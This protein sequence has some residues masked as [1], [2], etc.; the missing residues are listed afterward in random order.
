MGDLRGRNQAVAGGQKSGRWGE[1]QGAWGVDRRWGQCH[2][3]LVGEEALGTH[4]GDE[5]VRAEP[6]DAI[7]LELG[8]LWMR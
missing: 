2:N 7:E 8:A 5:R 4:A 1:G 6:F 3:D